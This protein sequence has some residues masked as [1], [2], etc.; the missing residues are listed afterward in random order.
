MIPRAW[1]VTWCALG[2]I[3]AGSADYPQR[4]AARGFYVM[5]KAAGFICRIEPVH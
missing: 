1:R 5:R 3:P 2:E 4:A